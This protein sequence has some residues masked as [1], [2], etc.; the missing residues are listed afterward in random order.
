[1]NILS[2]CE[3]QWK[4]FLGSFYK[5]F[6]QQF[7]HQPSRANLTFSEVFVHLWVNGIDCAIVFRRDKRNANI[8]IAS[9]IFNIIQLPLNASLQTFRNSSHRFCWALK[10]ARNS[11]SFAFI[12][13]GKHVYG[14]GRKQNTW[15]LKEFRLSFEKREVTFVGFAQLFQLFI[16]FCRRLI[17]FVDLLTGL[18]VLLRFHQRGSQDPRNQT[19]KSSRTRSTRKSTTLLKNSA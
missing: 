18:V 10:I 5:N 16:S 11:N 2:K 6:G 7:S 13:K 15:V 19:W 9:S 17:C 3:P 12:A 14:L 1:M 4:M 8:Y